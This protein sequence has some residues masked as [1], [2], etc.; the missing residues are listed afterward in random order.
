VTVQGL[1]EDDAAL[2]D[3]LRQRVEEAL[4]GLEPRERRD[5]AALRE[6]AR[7]AV[8]RSLRAWHG[9]KPVTEIHLVRI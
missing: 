7:L 9:K 1:S 3:E 8:R 6:A 2:T 4:A 5:D